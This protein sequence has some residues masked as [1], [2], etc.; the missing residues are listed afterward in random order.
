MR[1][2]STEVVKEDWD[3]KTDQS[4]PAELAV[5][6][7]KEVPSDVVVIT[8]LRLLR[9]VLLERVAAD[10]AL[11]RVFILLPLLGT[12]AFHRS[13][14][15]EFLHDRCFPLDKLVQELGEH[16]HPDRH[17]SKLIELAES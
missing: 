10:V 9:I 13:I 2:V 16:I 6:R 14:R 12:Q 4:L 11:R 17:H 1:I 3:P 15:P 5:S 7:A 8:E